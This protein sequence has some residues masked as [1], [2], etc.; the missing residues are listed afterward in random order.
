MS[1]DISGWTA[2]GRLQDIPPRG[3]RCLQ[4]AHGRVAVFRSAD[5]AVFAI[6]DRCPHRGGPL[7][8][9]IVHGQSV[10]CPLHGWVIDLQSGE[11]QGADHGR[12]RTYPVR[13]ESDRLLM[14]R[15]D[16]LAAVGIAA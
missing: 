3:A 12:V 13:V 8:Q 7:S 9:G 4:T 14:R 1:D 16:L 6:D 11:A 15:A 2:I 5:D 10:T